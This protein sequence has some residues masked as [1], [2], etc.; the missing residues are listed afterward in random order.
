MN[1]YTSAKATYGPKAKDPSLRNRMLEGVCETGEVFYVPSGW[2]HLV[3]NLES[4]IAVTQNFVSPANLA[5]VLY[6]LKHRSDQVSGFNIRADASSTERTIDS[7]E[8]NGE[9]D[10]ET[11][12]G[13]IFGRFCAALGKDHAEILMQGLKD[14]ARLETEEF[15]RRAAIATRSSIQKS[16][17]W[18][19]LTSSADVTETNGAV[20]FSFGFEFGDGPEGDL[21]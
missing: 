12:G 1:Y 9:D 20:S 14:L 6:F 5:G 16:T 11:G 2:W 19:T 3:V 18:N 17:L 15:N 10:D 13:A 7:G 21:L 4:S 8:Y